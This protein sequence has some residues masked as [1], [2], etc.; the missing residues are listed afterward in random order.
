MVGLNSSDPI[1]HHDGE[2][3][4]HFIHEG[5]YVGKS[6]PWSRRSL[7]GPDGGA[8]MLLVRWLF[9]TPVYQ[10]CAMLL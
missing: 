4:Q 5:V 7:G 6:I 8:G 2:F 10:Q 3:D 1:R 9:T